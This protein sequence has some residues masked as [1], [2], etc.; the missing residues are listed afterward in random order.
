[1]TNLPQT[2]NQIKYVS[3]FDELIST[4]FEGGI[5][6]ICWSRNLLVDFSE[7]VEKIEFSENMVELDEEYLCDLDLTAEGKH[8]REVILSDLKNLISVG[9][10][11]VLNVIKYYERDDS[12]P[13]FSTDVYSFHVDR[14]P[15]PTSTFLC[16]YYGECSEIVPN[17]QA[18]QKVLIPEIRQELQNMYDG[19]EE[20]FESFL[21]ENFFDLHYQANP[22]AQIVNLGIGQIWRLAV[23][24]PESQVLPCLHRAPNEKSGQKRLLLIC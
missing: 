17:S 3:N 18:N 14:S 22:D 8:A 16:T 1:M 7:I 11:P 2:S 9:A 21:S 20:D 6:A 19:E 5:N 15:I 24:H 12:F 23:D 4:P 10:S 13:F